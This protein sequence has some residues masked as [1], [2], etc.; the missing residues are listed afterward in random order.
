MYESVVRDIM[1]EEVEWVVKYIFQDFLNNV[2]DPSNLIHKFIVSFLI[3]V[4]WIGILKLGK[5]SIHA[6]TDNVKFTTVMYKIF[7]NVIGAISILLLL[8]IWM[9]LQKTVLFVLIVIAL[10]TVFSIKNL[11]TN[12]VAWFMFFI[13]KYFK[14]YE[15]YD[16]VGM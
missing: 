6:L 9:K 7:K 15:W 4:V 1:N 10:L 13:K 14:L 16:I 8:S 11:Y 2:N 5:K 12:L 3:V